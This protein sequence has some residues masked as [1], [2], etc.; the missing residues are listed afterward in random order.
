MSVPGTVTVRHWVQ[1][2]DPAKLE[3]AVRWCPMT[4][5]I[6]G[7]FAHDV[8]AHF[9]VCHALHGKLEGGLPRDLVGAPAASKLGPDVAVARLVERGAQPLGL[10]LQNRS[11]IPLTQ[12]VG[13][14]DGQSPLYVLRVRL[15]SC[16]LLGRLTDLRGL[17]RRPREVFE[18]PR[19]CGGDPKHRALAHLRQTRRGKHACVQDARRAHLRAVPAQL[20]WPPLGAHRHRAT[21]LAAGAVL[22]LQGHLPVRAPLQDLLQGQAVAPQ[23]VVPADGPV[24]EHLEP[25]ALV[26]SLLDQHRGGPIPL[27]REVLEHRLGLEPVRP[28]SQ[29]NVRVRARRA[30]PRVLL[31]RQARGAPHRQ[32]QDPLGQRGLDR[33]D[34]RIWHNGI[35]EAV[36][37]H[38]KASDRVLDE[39][40]DR[41]PHPRQVQQALGSALEAHVDLRRA[42]HEHAHTLEE[43]RL[44]GEP[45]ELQHQHTLDGQALDAQT[46]AFEPQEDVAVRVPFKARL[47]RQVVDVAARSALALPVDVDPP[48]LQRVLA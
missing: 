34:V 38:E 12:V 9:C 42:V 33:E 24:V 4:W 8:E 14:K 30:E 19:A 28:A 47:N 31:G 16:A 10:D 44:V 29:N 35:A 6:A 21:V 2:S 22:E 39:P 5:Q 17:P 15:A 7:L 27:G 36:R 18:Q 37:Q 45:H 46:G 26:G 3:P 48:E 32:V 23:E 25:D 11:D 40:L 13:A 43:G 1:F 41:L 20:Q